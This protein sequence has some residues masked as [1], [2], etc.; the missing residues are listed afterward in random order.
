M[1]HLTLK[2]DSATSLAGPQHISMV[3]MRQCLTW[4]VGRL[5][6]SRALLELGAGAA[7]LDTLKP[8]KKLTII[9]AAT[10]PTL[11]PILP[12]LQL[13]PFLSASRLD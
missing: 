12:Q 1:M 7:K 10:T 9:L 5:L 11:S 6:W 8:A 2:V 3:G 4:S 13:A